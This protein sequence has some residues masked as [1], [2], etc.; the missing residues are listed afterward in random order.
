MKFTVLE[1]II[2]Q[3]IL[4]KEGDYITFKIIRDLRNELS[5]TEDEIKKFK[6]KQDSERITW[7]EK[8]ELPKDIQIGEKLN[9]IITDSLNKINGEGKLNSNNIS[10]YEK[11][12]VNKE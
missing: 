9:S 11:F 10:L 8:S 4:P 5:F 7:D 12:I 6:I 3:E 2:L 1:R